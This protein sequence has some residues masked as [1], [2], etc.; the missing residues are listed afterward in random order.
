MSDYIMNRES[1]KRHCEIMCE[2]FK[3]ERDDER[4]EPLGKVLA[5]MPLPDPYKGEQHG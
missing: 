5:W 2:R 4:H 1:L 3:G